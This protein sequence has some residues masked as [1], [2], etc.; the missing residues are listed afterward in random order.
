MDIDFESHEGIVVEVENEVAS[1]FPGVPNFG[2][3]GKK[4]GKHYPYNS[5]VPVG[6]CETPVLMR[7]RIEGTKAEPAEFVLAPPADHVLTATVLL[8]QHPTAWTGF[9]KE[10]VP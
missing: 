1:S 2:T 6:T 4:Q 5:H 3:P 7:V 10:Q 9:L 8:D